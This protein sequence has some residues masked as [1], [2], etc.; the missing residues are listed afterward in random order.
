MSDPA[1]MLEPMATVQEPAERVAL[2]LEV[3]YEHSQGRVTRCVADGWPT[4]AL[5]GEVGA[6]VNDRVPDAAHISCDLVPRTGTKSGEHDQLIEV[7]GRRSCRTSVPTVDRQHK[8][9]RALGDFWWLYVVFDCGTPSTLPG[10]RRGASTAGG[11]SSLPG[12]S[13]PEST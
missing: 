2:D 1:G 9:A 11:S 6:W 4:T 13:S 5:I 12:S 8:I 3:R 10:Y 7:K